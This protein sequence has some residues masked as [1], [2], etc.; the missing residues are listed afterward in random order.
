MS[1]AH[2]RNKQ[3]FLVRM[4]NFLYKDND[5]FG[6]GAFFLTH[7]VVQYSCTAIRSLSQAGVSLQKTGKQLRL[8]AASHLKSA[9]IGSRIMC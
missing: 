8:Y 2:S 7:T 4:R 5:H 6:S 1:S 9:G 3:R